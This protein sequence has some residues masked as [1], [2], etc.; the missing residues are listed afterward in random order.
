MQRSAQA[1]FQSLVEAAGGRHAGSAIPVD[2]VEVLADLLPAWRQSN[3]EFR[4][5]Q[6]HFDGKPGLWHAFDEL[7][8][9]EDPD[10][11]DRLRK[12]VIV[13]LE[14]RSWQRIAPPRGIT[15]LLPVLTAGPAI[16]D[17]VDRGPS[18]RRFTRIRMQPV[19]VAGSVLIE[20]A[21]TS[22]YGRLGSST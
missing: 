22:A 8:S 14:A 17:G 4:D 5:G 21:V 10:R 7:Y 19:V 1:A 11:W 15:L 6:F 3:A 12:E 20:P 13:E 2:H 18:P 16:A 9:L